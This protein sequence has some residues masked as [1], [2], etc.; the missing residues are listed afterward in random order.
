MEEHGS[1]DLARVRILIHYKS[2]QGVRSELRVLGVECSW[3][4]VLEVEEASSLPPFQWRFCGEETGVWEDEECRGFD[5]R[6]TRVTGAH[7]FC[8]LGKIPRA[9]GATSST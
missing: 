2:A 8:H 3:L 5:F 6:S 1:T 9:C 4:R 7:A